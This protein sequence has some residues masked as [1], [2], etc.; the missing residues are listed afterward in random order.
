MKKLRTEIIA[1]S[2][3][4]LI[5]S[6]GKLS[7]MGIFDEI[8]VEKFPG[9]FINKYLVATIIGTPEES[10]SLNVKLEEEGGK[11]NL[12]NPLLLNAKL[13]ITGKHN[14][15]VTLQQVGFEKEGVYYFK[16][17][18]GNDEVGSTKLEVKNKRTIN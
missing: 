13:S 4:A 9:G 6:D 1:L 11:K 17:Y 7:V 12:L 18:T 2:D 5:S 15:V 14:V 3:Y 8:Q 10:Y 16:I